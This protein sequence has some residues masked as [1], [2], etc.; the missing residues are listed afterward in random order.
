MITAALCL[1]GLFVALGVAVFVRFVATAP[2]VDDGPEFGEDLYLGER[3]R[4]G[5]K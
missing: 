2:R 4:E 3:F 1:L 5:H